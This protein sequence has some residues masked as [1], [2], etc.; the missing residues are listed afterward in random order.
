MIS[1]RKLTSMLFLLLFA[2]GMSYGQTVNIFVHKWPSGNF[3]DPNNVQNV[4]NQ[5]FNTVNVTSGLVPSTGNMSTYDV[6]IMCELTYSGTN[7]ILSNAQ[8]Q[9]VENFVNQGGH[10]VWVSENSTTGNAPGSNQSLTAIQNLWGINLARVQ[11]NINPV[12]PYHGGGGPGG[13]SAG[14]P[15]LGTTSSYDFFSGP[16]GLEQNCVYA[17]SA[18]LS[19][20]NHS[21]QFSI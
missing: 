7:S 21:S 17:R 19:S 11:C 3:P 20:C 10:V 18:G 9:V 6:L 4:Y 1:A 5:V 8:R 13:L 16:A 12:V 15:S 2:A 14:A